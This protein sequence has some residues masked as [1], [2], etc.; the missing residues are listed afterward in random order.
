M[1]EAQFVNPTLNYI[2]SVKILIRQHSISRP[3]QQLPT[4]CGAQ[5]KMT[6]IMNFLG[7]IGDLEIPSDVLSSSRQSK[8]RASRSQIPE[9]Q[10]VD[11]RRHMLMTC[12]DSHFFAM[13]FFFF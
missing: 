5:K 10:A 2:A 3:F 11:L 13:F 4:E 6:S 8:G 1:L 7:S 12:S 9:R